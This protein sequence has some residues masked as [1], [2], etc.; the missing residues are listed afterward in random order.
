MKAF[1][2]KV[3]LEPDEDGGYV[4]VCPSLPGCYSQGETIEQAL[5]NI[6][7]AIE[8]CLED[9]QE[10]GEPVPDPSNVLIGS[11]VVNR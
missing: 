6:R 10:H 2:F 8:L 9:M 5:A 1:D 4:V 11:V 7:E 3:L